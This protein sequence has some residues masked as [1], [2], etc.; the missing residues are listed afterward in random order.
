MD[1]SVKIHSTKNQE[2]QF[3]CHKK[4]H[5]CNQEIRAKIHYIINAQGLHP[6]SATRIFKFGD[7]RQDIG[8]TKDYQQELFTEL[9][10]LE[11]ILYP[12]SLQELF[13]QQFL[14]T[15][16]YSSDWSPLDRKS[17]RLNSSH[18]QQSRMP[19]SA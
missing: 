4:L 9:P 15:N 6:R 3:N 14:I 11:P 7:I 10:F 13:Y 12:V 5:R 2:L 8:H 19:S 17:T 18:S 16:D 1:L